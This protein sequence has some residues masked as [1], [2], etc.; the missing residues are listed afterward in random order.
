MAD[1]PPP[2]NTNSAVAPVAPVAPVTPALVVYALFAVAAVAQLLS[3]GIAAPLPLM[4]LIGVVGVIIAHVKR[5]DARGTWVESHL[6]WQIRTFWW[7]FVWSMIGWLILIV[8]GI[9]LI[10]IPLAFL[11]WAGV[12]IWVLYRVIRGYL[13]FKDS[14]PIPGL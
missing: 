4:S 3:S 11:V 2:Q 5:S 1:F 9:I 14:R 10:G 12:S 13:Q 6:S 7:S 8:L